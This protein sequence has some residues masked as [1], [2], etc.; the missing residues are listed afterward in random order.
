VVNLLNMTI[1]P[2][3]TNNPLRLLGITNPLPHT[4]LSTLATL[5]LDMLTQVNMEGVVM[6]GAAMECSNHLSLNN[7]DNFRRE[8]HTL[9]GIHQ[10]CSADMRENLVALK[11]ETI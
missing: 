9:N 3:I 4:P 10:E 1:H 8:H 2:N 6:V 5:S 11:M 7:L